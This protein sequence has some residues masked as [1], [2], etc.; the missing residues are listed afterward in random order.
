MRMLNSYASGCGREWAGEGTAGTW[1]RRMTALAVRLGANLWPRIHAYAA[2]RW[3]AE[4]WDSPGGNTCY[5]PSAPPAAAPWRAWLP[6]PVPPLLPP[7]RSRRSG[8]ARRWPAG[9]QACGASRGGGKARL[10][11]WLK[12]GSAH[13]C[14]TNSRST[15]HQVGTGMPGRNPPHRPEASCIYAPAPATPPAP[16]ILA[17]AAAAAA[18]LCRRCRRARPLAHVDN[19]EARA[20]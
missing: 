5:P 19:S 1:G 12:A 13:C 3:H 8:P 2:C 18:L 20:L 6:P 14:G 9:A 16:P 11:A 7:R 15:N 10:L 4:A 17:A